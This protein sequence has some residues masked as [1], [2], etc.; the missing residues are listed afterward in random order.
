MGDDAFLKLM[1]DYYAANT[2][3][4]VTAQSFLA[5]AGMGNAAAQLDAID[6]PGGPAYLANDIWRRLATAV[7]VYG[8][9][10]EAG[11]NRYAAEQ[12]QSR[13]LNGYESEVPVY[14]DFEAS[15]DLLRHRDVVFVGRPEANSALALWAAKLGLDYLGADFKIDGQT[16]A[17]ERDALILATQNPLDAA[18]MVLMVAGNDALSTVKAQATD[19]PSDEYVVFKDGEKP[20]EGFLAHGTSATQTAARN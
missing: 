8:T 12:L 17:S 13:F 18:H 5:Q 20:L 7:I 16:H 3:K 14:K 1:D 9:L 6:P 2:T 4:T 10:R 15:D 11:A 19:L